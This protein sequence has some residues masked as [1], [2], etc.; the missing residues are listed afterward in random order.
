MIFAGRIETT[1]LQ[2][3][4]CN[5]TALLTRGLDMP[6]ATIAQGYSTTGAIT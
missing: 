4:L 5:K 6:F 2:E 3:Y 1:K